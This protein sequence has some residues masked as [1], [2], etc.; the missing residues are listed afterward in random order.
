M[1]DPLLAAASQI[2][3]FGWFDVSCATKEFPLMK[4]T[5][6]MWTLCERPV[7]TSSRSEA[8]EEPLALA[9]DEA[10]CLPGYR[11]VGEGCYQFLAQPSTAREA[12]RACAAVGGRSVQ[13]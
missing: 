13:V 4:F 8:E 1:V 5:L 6:E 12:R 7:D 2:R 9:L 10:G 3:N 11:R